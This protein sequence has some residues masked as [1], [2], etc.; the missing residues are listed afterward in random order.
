VQGVER[1]RLRYIAHLADSG[2]PS[3][4]KSGAAAKRLEEAQ[5]NAHGGVWNEKIT[6]AEQIVSKRQAEVEQFLQANGAALVEELTPEAEAV[7]EEWQQLVSQAR[8]LGP[9]TTA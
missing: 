8:E 9:S 5:A 2:D 4:A 7:P 6:A 1:A 3:G